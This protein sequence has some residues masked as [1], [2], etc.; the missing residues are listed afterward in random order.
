VD[1][2]LL[3]DML[4]KGELPRLSKLLG[5]KGKTLAAL[6]LL[7]RVSLLAGQPLQT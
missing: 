3:Y 1:R 6:L 2:D 7:E 4:E 5:G